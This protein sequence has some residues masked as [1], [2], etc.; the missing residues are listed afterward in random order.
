M[1]I[2]FHLKTGYMND[3]NGLIYFKGRYHAFFQC[4][5]G[6][7]NNLEIPV[8]WGHAVSEDLVHWHQVEDALLPDKPYE[9]DRGCWSGGAVVKD[10]RLYV[11]YTGAARPNAS[12]NVAWSDDGIHFTKN[13]GNPV[14]ARGPMDGDPWDFRDPNV[15]KVGDTYH[16]V[17]GNAG[18]NGGRIVRYTSRDLLDWS[19][20]GVLYENGELGPMLE[21][22]DFFPL[23]DRFVLLLSLYE[24]RTVMVVGTFDGETFTPERI[25]APE[26]GCAFYAPQTFQTPDGR[27]I[28]LGWVFETD[29]RPGCSYIGAL[30]A[31]RELRL[32]DGDVRS[33]P[34]KELEKYLKDTDPC[35]R[36]T[37]QSVQI[38]RPDGTAFGYTSDFLHTPFRKFEGEQQVRYDGPVENVKILRDGDTLEVFI[39]DGSCNFIVHTCR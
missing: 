34:A 16:M 6:R 33:V 24:R 10:G 38:L 27:R 2:H 23:G 31:A 36:V 30:S 28:M 35:V 39:N 5:F 26:Q 21:C 18:P 37:E 11:F 8:G 32:V 25:C 17:L 29:R 19:Y 7:M 20:A 13:P 12:V 9:K 4:A 14:I 3:P 1:D 15:L 22:P